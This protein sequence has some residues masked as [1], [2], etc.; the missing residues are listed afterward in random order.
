MWAGS[1][2]CVMFL[3][4]NARW[5]RVMHTSLSLLWLSAGAAAV[6]TGTTCWAASSCTVSE[7]RHQEAPKP[8]SKKG[9][10]GGL[11]VT[12][13]FITPS[14]LCLL[15]LRQ[16]QL[17]LPA[18]E[19]GS[20]TSSR[21]VS[22]ERQADQTDARVAWLPRWCLEG[23][24]WIPTL[25]YILMVCCSTDRSCRF[26]VCCLDVVSVDSW[27]YLVRNILHQPSGFIQQSH[28]EWVHVFFFFFLRVRAVLPSSWPAC[29]SIDWLKGFCWALQSGK[30]PS[31]Q[32][33]VCLQL[34]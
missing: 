16:A 1:W 24:R 10:S 28:D 31:L 11:L 3:D 8:G 25:W 22:W 12:S 21:S 18:F 6:F 14:S 26:W 34:W 27:T 15:P 13:T 30:V 2:R 17:A 29:I 4:G 5:S 33:P 7:R 9:P 32:R 19:A 20:K 23:N